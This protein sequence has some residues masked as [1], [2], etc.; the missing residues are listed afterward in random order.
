MPVIIL[1]GLIFVFVWI[2]YKIALY[3]NGLR[4]QAWLR[5]IAANVV[6]IAGQKYFNVDLGLP[7]LPEP[8]PGGVSGMVS[9]VLPTIGLHLIRGYFGI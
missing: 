6:S 7:A 4:E 2:G 3:E 8:A 5:G 9:A 1:L